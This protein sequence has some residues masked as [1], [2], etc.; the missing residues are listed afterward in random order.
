MLFPLYNVLP[1]VYDMKINI[2][3]NMKTYWKVV[4]LFGILMMNLYLLMAFLFKENDEEKFKETEN[5]IDQLGLYEIMQ[6]IFMYTNTTKFD[7]I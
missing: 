1:P 7:C 3:R 4:L 5:T 6:L 2:K